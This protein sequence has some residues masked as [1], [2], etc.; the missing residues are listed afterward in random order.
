MPKYDP[1]LTAHKS[2]L[3]LVQ[4]VGL[5][6]SPPALVKAQAVLDRNVVD[7]QQTLLSIVRQPPRTAFG[8]QEAPYLDDFPRFTEQVLGWAPEDLAGGP[9][10]PEL[11]DDLELALPDYGD[12]LRPTY[13]VVDGMADDKVLMLVRIEATG[14]S[15]DQPPAERTGWH[16]SPQSRLERLL[17]EREISAGLLL[18]GHELRLVYAPRGE[19]SGHLTFPVPAMCEVAGRPI[20]SAL[21]LLLGEH[22]VFSAP[23]GRRLLDLLSASRKYQSEVSN[24]LS[25][26]VL[27]ALWDLLAGFQAADEASGRFLLFDRAAR[28]HPDHVYGGLLTVLL[29]LVFLLYAEDQGLMPD[30]EVYA[31]NYSVAGL[32][33]RLRQDAGRYPDTMDQRYGAWA[34]LLSLFR[35]VFDG[36][37]HGG[38]GGFRLPTRHGQLFNPDEYPF[39]EAR[40]K[41]KARVRHERFEAPKVSDGC[42]HRVLE[43]LLVLDGERLSY[44]ALDVEQIGSVYEAMMGFEVERAFGRSIAVGSNHVVFDVDKLLEEPAGARKKWL[45][46]HAECDL[47]GKGLAALKAAETAEDVVAAL[48]RKISPRTP[49]LLPPDSLYLQ[50]GEERRRSGSHYTPRE[51]TEPI[52]RTTLRPVLA[53]LGERPAPEQILDLKVCDPAM[54]SGAF[55]VEACRQLAKRLVAAWELHDRMPEIPPDE[56]PL[57]H[58]RRL[59]AQRCLYGVDKN[60]FAVNLA[61]LSLWLVTLARDHAFTFLDHALKC[62]DSLVGLTRKQI[63]A[64]DWQ[65]PKKLEGPIMDLLADVNESVREAR[66]SRERIQELD[67]GDYGRKKAAWYEAENALHDARL[68]GDLV[69]AAFFG[70]G[71]AKARKDLRDTYQSRVMLWREGDLEVAELQGFV[72]ELRGGE[73]PVV[74]FHWEIE[75]PEVF[76]RE[77]PGFDAMVG[78][79]PFLGGTKL[80][81]AFGRCWRDFA[82]VFVANGETGVRGAG[83][84]CAY[85]LLR[86][87]SLLRRQAAFG[88]VA[89]NSISQGD[90]R[91]IGLAQIASFGGEIFSAKSSRN[92]PGAAGIEIAEVWVTKGT[93]RGLRYLDGLAVSRI[94][95]FLDTSEKT[96]EPQVL[97]SNLD[98]AFEGAKV[99]GSGFILKNEEA[100][101]L[102]EVAENNHKVIRQFLSGAD[103]NTRPDSSPSRY[104]INFWGW[105]LHRGS[106]PNDYAG[107]VAVDFPECLEIVQ[108]RVRQERL[109]KPPDSSWNRAIRERWWQYGLWRPA[110]FEAIHDL[111]RVLVRSVVSNIHCLAF[112]P[113]G[114]IFSNTTVVFAFDQWS[115]FSTLQSE[116]HGCWLRR[117]SST[118][119]KDTR[120]TPST[121]FQTFPFPE[122][123]QTDPTLEATGKAYY[124]FRADLMIRNN[125]GLTKTYNR[126]HDPEE[127]HPDIVKLRELHA[128]MDRAV[129]DAYGWTDVATDC[130]FLLDY[131]I[132]EET[133]SPRKKKPYR[134]RWPEAVHDEVLARLLDLNQKRYQEEVLAGLHDGKKGKQKK[135]RSKRKK[136]PAA[137]P[138]TASLPLFEDELDGAGSG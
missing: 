74:P 110:L 114:T 53:N 45:K 67:E 128:D 85:F 49:R 34:W 133:W 112:L 1:Q 113:T 124:E 138:A 90:T 100:K 119:R 2:W 47:T 41:G 58:A 11:A 46:D 73:R 103:I 59:V 95:P 136:K 50:P 26:Q 134:Y 65:P 18:N 101:H 62:G 56:D 51:L 31:R 99:L 4:P 5:V 122:G 52:V 118:M 97:V 69:I 96:R 28:D 98:C 66:V 135:A 70:A 20:L 27:G 104:A 8:D 84:L 54:G 115:A 137:K 40:T 75:F 63:G 48:G 94:T 13:A 9:G 16:A 116:L 3:G 12:T 93:Y 42:I 130:E 82:V 117:Y 29:R 129:L 19:S 44:R 60:P 22:R 108:D 7:R 79:P 126:F 35:L 64:F 55:L 83:D 105:P 107:P 23:D 106:A 68:V 132:D 39:L 92:W 89:T 71:K 109:N 24:K 77:N 57:L 10:G 80:E 14:R 76:G 125:E 21:H 127:N 15:L 131:E 38:A 30:D 88:L 36:G 86:A 37:G 25:E 81:P 61:K 87:F 72:D 91:K 6:V 102:L 78:N 121:C 32:Y 43:A 123:W 33:A 17:R 111:K 120:Y